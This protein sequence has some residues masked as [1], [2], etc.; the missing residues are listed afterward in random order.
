MLRYIGPIIL[1]LA[2]LALLA[3]AALAGSLPRADLAIKGQGASAIACAEDEPCWNWA[4]MGNHRRGVV[5]LEG[6]PL[7]VGPCRFQRLWYRGLLRYSVRFD[8]VSYP[9]LDRLRGDGTARR[10][11][12]NVQLY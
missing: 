6:D 2:I 9:T 3:D 4:T 11:V 12:C 1:A 5:T 7:V 10:K 8:G